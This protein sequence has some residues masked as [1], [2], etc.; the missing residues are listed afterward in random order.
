MNLAN[1]LTMS[2]IAL[3]LV[4]IVLLLFPFEQLGFNFPSLVLDGRIMVDTKYLIA[5][6]IFIIASLTDYFDG[7]VAR[8]YNMITEANNA[9]DEIG[10]KPYD[11]YYAMFNYELLRRKYGEKKNDATTKSN[12]R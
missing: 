2:R 11:Y 5:G 9:M 12:K 6:I 1:K 10:L 3:S 7:I 8:K 4:I